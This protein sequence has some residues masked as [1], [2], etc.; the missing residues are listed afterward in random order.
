[1]F[2]AEDMTD[3]LQSLGVVDVMDPKKSNMHPLF[4]NDTDLNAYD[5][6]FNRKG[7]IKFSTHGIEAAAFS[8]DGMGRDKDSH[9]KVAHADKPFVFLV[10]DR[11]TNTLMFAGRVTNPNGWYLADDDKPP[12]HHTALILFVVLLLSTILFRSDVCLQRDLP[13]D[14]RHR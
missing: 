10:M 7:W 5:D 9:A 11:G 13:R 14:E 2:Y 1:M 3:E 12:H 4:K 8:G 6:A